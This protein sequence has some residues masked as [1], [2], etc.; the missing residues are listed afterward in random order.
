MKNKLLS[1]TFLA[2]MA[3][4][5]AQTPIA[6]VHI[7]QPVLICN[8]GGCTAL[9]AQYYEGKTTENYSVASIPYTPFFPFSG[10]TVID[11][12]GDDEWTPIINLPFSFC[13]YGVIYN[14]ILV[15]TN[16]VITFDTTNQ[17]PGGNCPWSFN[18]TI[19]SPAFPIRNAIYGTYQDN[20]IRTVGNGGAIT[21]SALQNVNYYV[22]DVG[23]NAAPNR[24]FVANFNELPMYQCGVSAG[25]QTSQIV[26]YE[27]TNVIDINIKTRTAC[28]TWNSGSGLIGLQ[29]EAGTLAT[30]PPARNTGTWTTTNEAWRFS[31]SGNLNTQLSWY[32]N[33]VLVNTDINPLVVCPT[34]EDHFSAV[35][36]YTNCSGAPTTMTAEWTDSLF[37]PPLPISDPDDSTVCGQN[38]PPYLVDLTIN[39]PIVLNGQI[40]SDYDVAYYENLTDA[41]NQ[42]SN[43]IANPAVYSFTDSH[44]IYMSIV[45][46]VST[47]CAAIK[48]FSV[49]VLPSVTAPTGNSQQNF[50]TGQTLADL[51][52]TG[53]NIIW[54]DDAV[55]GNVL[56]SNTVLQN[57]ATYYASQ[58]VNGCESRRLNPTRLAVTVHLVLANT[59]FSKNGFAVYP[60]P[61]TTIV[62]ISGTTDIESIGV[63]NALGQEIMRQLQTGK[64]V[65]VDVSQWNSGIYFI[66]INDANQLI[67]I[68]KK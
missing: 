21:N 6:G 16:G 52:V 3:L 11:G 40:L 23:V 32:D 53:D 35:V 31:P 24:V 55:A 19:P 34:E 18:S 60:N 14:Q 7:D 5:N 8:P 43:Y 58:T 28:T 38:P 51:A 65:K 12:A 45:D 57:N 13:F 20:D 25:L 30:V 48:P 2:F 17:I 33:G 68:I 47:G 4:T 1:I 39:E 61:V 62:T 22:L 63:Y 26:I 44:I 41:Q 37:A 15:G 42:A 56:P 64:E 46:L 10:G 29:N 66:K 9:H 49:T 36:S 27:T 54:Y 50:T 59:V 67:K